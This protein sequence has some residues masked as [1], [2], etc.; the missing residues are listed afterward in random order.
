LLKW[1]LT[2]MVVIVYLLHQDNWLWHD[3]TLVFGLPAHRAG[4]SRGLCGTLR[5]HDVGTGEIRV[6]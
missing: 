6:A 5:R 3:K 2:I 4:I 1:L